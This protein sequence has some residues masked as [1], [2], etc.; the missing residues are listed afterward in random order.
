M[1]WKDETGL[2]LLELIVV[3]AI[4]GMVAAIAIPQYNKVLDNVRLESDAKK[5]ASVLQ[6]ARQEAVNSG[7]DQVIYFYPQS[8]KYSVL[9]GDTYWFNSGITY[10]G[11]PNFKKKDLKPACIFT[12]SG[13]PSHAGT[14]TLQNRQGKVL[15]IIVSAVAGRVRVSDSPPKSWE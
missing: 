5:M 12:P 6:Y 3:I 14:A 4:L 1:N 15:Y 8:T 11:I 7:A 13:V 10:G 2:T 9:H